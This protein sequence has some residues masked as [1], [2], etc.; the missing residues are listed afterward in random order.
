M[1]MV[2]QEN[3]KEDN[4]PQLMKCFTKSPAYRH[5]TLSGNIISSCVKWQAHNHTPSYRTGFSFVRF[6][7]GA[8]CS[9]SSIVKSAASAVFTITINHFTGSWGNKIK[10]PVEILVNCTTLNT[11]V[12]FVFQ[13][14]RDSWVF[15]PEPYSGKS[16]NFVLNDRRKNSFLKWVSNLGPLV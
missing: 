10:V 7:T 14:Y 3:Y 2:C 15:R 5:N 1:G 12:N 13:F 16:A 4:I 9:L 8:E 11:S 6:S